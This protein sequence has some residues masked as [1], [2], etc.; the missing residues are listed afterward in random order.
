[1]AFRSIKAIQS[2]C[3]TH[4][5][6]E[7]VALVGA[8]ADGIV[9]LTSEQIGIC[10][11]E[12]GAFSAFQPAAKEDRDAI[13]GMRFQDR[14]YTGPGKVRVYATEGGVTIE[15][16]GRS[17]DIPAGPDHLGAPL[18]LSHD[19]RR[20]AHVRSPSEPQPQVRERLRT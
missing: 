18:G 2:R 6:V 8:A 13:D 9:L 16:N 20:V 14:T 17:R 15:S 10:S 3:H 4:S 12:P 5:P 1:M 7:V 11:A 19:R